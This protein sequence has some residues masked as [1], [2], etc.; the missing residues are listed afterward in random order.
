[1][2][3]IIC[4]TYLDCTNVCNEK[5]CMVDYEVTFRPAC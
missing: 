4:A 2:P 3:Y 1:M 5:R